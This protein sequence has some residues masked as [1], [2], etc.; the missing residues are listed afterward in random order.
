[1]S[2]D[3]TGVL[4]LDVAGVSGFVRPGGLWR[5]VWAVAETGSSNADLF[6]AAGAG[7]AEGTVLVAEAQTAGRGWLGRRWAS[8]SRAGLTFSLLLRL[9]GV[10]AGLLS[11]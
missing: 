11:W 6:A 7:A 4:S 10:P 1:M 3:T 8:S 9:D 2:D 5:E